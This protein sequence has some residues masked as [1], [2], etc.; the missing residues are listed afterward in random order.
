ML[1][2]Y[3]I[4]ICTNTKE[5]DRYDKVACNPYPII[6]L[7]NE[8]ELKHKL[9][10]NETKDYIKNLFRTKQLYDVS[11]FR[12]RHISKDYYIDEFEWKVSDICQIDY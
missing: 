9:S 2:V 7:G 10:S 1:D 6:V 11:V 5:Q 4:N 8:V 3:A 12:V